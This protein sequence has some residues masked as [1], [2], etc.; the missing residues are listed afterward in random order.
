LAPLSTALN[1]LTQ[2]FQGLSMTQRVIV[3]ALGLGIFSVLVYWS[4]QAAQGPEMVPL[5]TD[6]DP[7]DASEIADALDEEGMVYELADGG[8]TI[9]VPAEDVYR[10]RLRMVSRGLPRGSGVGLEIMDRTDLAMTDF[11][12]HINFMRGLQ[13]ELARTISQISGVKA[14]KVHLVIPEPSLF[15]SEREEASAAV[16]LELNPGVKL[17]EEQV[18]AIVHLVAHSVEGLAESNV[19]VVDSRG[20][21]LSAGLND[22]HSVNG[23]VASF[24]HTERAFEASL[25][26][27]VQSLLEQVFGPGNVIVRVK[28]EL[29]FDEQVINRNL[30]QPVS[31]DEGIVRSIQELEEIFS[32]DAGVAAGV[33]GAD[34]N[35]PSY[36]TPEGG[37]TSQYTRT[38]SIKN[39]EINEISERIV[40]APGTVK[41]LSVA[42]VINGDLTPEQ[43]AAVRD[44]VSAAIGLDPSRTDQITVS[45]MVFDTTLAEQLKASLQSDEAARQAARERQQRLMYY[46]A[47][48]AGVVLVLTVGLFVLARRRRPQPRLQQ[49][50]VEE[51]EEPPEPEAE[52]LRKEIM[53]LARR[54]PEDVAT[55][56]KTWLAE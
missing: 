9:L 38:E 2:I 39:Y 8:T 17:E 34:S 31:G 12:R 7:Q 25:Q 49:P 56:I 37:G 3:V 33:A 18:R 24:L 6:L 21:L 55:L 36:Q 20:H 1:Q 42:V 48:A 46:S 32:G 40:V 11:E 16:L 43:E 45:G 51:K 53:R 23:S 30:F 52:R 26:D 10:L 14:A 15:I 47:I 27:S 44:T 35:L 22:E 29:N 28:A 5:F 4:F 13:G 50:A 41:R 54:S 19:T